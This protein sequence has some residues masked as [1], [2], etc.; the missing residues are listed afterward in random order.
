MMI[1]AILMREW[2]GRRAVLFWAVF[3]VAAGMAA[4]GVVYRP[5]DLD[6][7]IAALEIPP[8]WLKALPVPAD[9]SAPWQKVRLEVR[10]L[11]GQGGEA[12]RQA[13]ALTWRYLVQNRQPEQGD[14]EYPLYLFLGGEYAW[15]ARIYQDRIRENPKRESNEYKNLASIL[16]HY[17]ERDRARELLLSALNHLPEPPWREMRRAEIHDRIGD[18]HVKTGNIAA[19]AKA[20]QTAIAA[21]EAANP[22]YGRHQIPRHISKIRAKMD[23]MR[24]DRLNLKQVADGIWQGKSLGYVDEITTAVTMRKGRIV[25]IQVR[26]RENIE[27]GATRIIPQRMVERQ[28]L[29]V[30]AVT[31]ATVTAQAIV[32]AVYRALQQGGLK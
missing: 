16:M 2:R 19:A 1:M 30:D 14:H 27:Q 7:E 22:Q 25:D 4:E 24:M 31:G 3:H 32:E 13:I 29:Q 6:R 5:G 18:I 21:Y 9:T 10:K 11:L 26:H 8:A 23:L 28:S 12:S 17:G 15:A 20:Y